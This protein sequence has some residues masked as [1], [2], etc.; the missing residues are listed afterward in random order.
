MRFEPGTRLLRTKR[1]LSRRWYAISAHTAVLLEFQSSRSAKGNYLGP[2]IAAFINPSWG[3]LIKMIERFSPFLLGVDVKYRQLESLGGLASAAEPP[4]TER[5]MKC[6][7]KVVKFCK[8]NKLL[9]PGV[10][11]LALRVSGL[12]SW[13]VAHWNMY[14]LKKWIRGFSVKLCKV[15]EHTGVSSDFLT[16]CEHF[17]DFECLL[18][19]SIIF[20]GKRVFLD[21]QCILFRRGNSLPPHKKSEKI[22]PTPLDLRETLS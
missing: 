14:F 2:R 8:L 19:L 5:L 12:L 13:F 3:N 22:A 4:Y 10:D 9:H 7:K 18:F 21:L 1:P 15:D 20:F 16:N 6:T 17:F 11:L